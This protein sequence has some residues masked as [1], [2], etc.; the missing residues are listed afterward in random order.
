M[1]YGYHRVNEPKV[2][3]GRRGIYYALAHAGPSGVA[4][5]TYR[6]ISAMPS[7]HCEWT[8]ALGRHC[9][10]LWFIYYLFTD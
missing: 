7:Q 9:L 5:I 10:Y 4:L 6:A 3:I 1:K 8:D 2:V